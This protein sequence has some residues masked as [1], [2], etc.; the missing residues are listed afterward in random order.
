MCYLISYVFS[1]VHCI[2]SCFKLRVNLE[3][4]A[5]LPSN[6]QG[7]GVETNLPPEIT[8]FFRPHATVL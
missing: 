1:L 5:L 6:W 8:S 3:K 2:N 7:T 4:I